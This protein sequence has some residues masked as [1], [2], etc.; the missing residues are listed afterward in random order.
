MLTNAVWN[1]MV[2]GAGLLLNSFK[3]A[4]SASAYTTTTASAASADE[5]SKASLMQADSRKLPPELHCWYTAKSYLSCS[6][7]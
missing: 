6:L 4:D 1:T 5:R 2:I 3:S 7:I